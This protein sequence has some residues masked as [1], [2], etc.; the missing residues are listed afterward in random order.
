MVEKNLVENSFSPPCRKWTEGGWED[1]EMW[2]GKLKWMNWCFHS[3]E[4][5]LWDVVKIRKMMWK[6]HWFTNLQIHLNVGASDES[7]ERSLSHLSISRPAHKWRWRMTKMGGDAST[8]MSNGTST[9]GSG[10]SCLGSVGISAKGTF[11]HIFWPAISGTS[12]TISGA[13]S[14][15]TSGASSA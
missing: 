1:G 4:G 7:D 5:D 3:M 15:A 14:R 8:K 9:V 6:Q 2:R 12:A 11:K 10:P 13:T